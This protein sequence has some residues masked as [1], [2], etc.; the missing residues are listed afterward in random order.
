MARNLRVNDKL[1][2]TGTGDNWPGGQ[3][4]ARPRPGDRTPK[5]EGHCGQP[6]QLPPAHHTPGHS[7]HGPGLR[8]AGK[9]PQVTH[10]Q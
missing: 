9:M 10:H 6:C 7:A 3:V 1:Q 5:V 2:I 4:C 8:D